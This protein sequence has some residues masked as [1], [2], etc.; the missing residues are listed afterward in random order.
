MDSEARLKI[1]SI[2]FA[3]LWAAGMIWWTGIDIA[4]VVMFTV[5]GAVAGVIWYFCMG[6]FTRRHTQ[7]RR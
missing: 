1:A 7:Q 3:V 6:L 4:N 5:G 2:L